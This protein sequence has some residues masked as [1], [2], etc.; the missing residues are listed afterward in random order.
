MGSGSGGGQAAM[1]VVWVVLAVLAVGGFAAFSLLRRHGQRA[2]ADK[3][4]D[5]R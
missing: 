1:I 5:E 4:G 3:T 2:G